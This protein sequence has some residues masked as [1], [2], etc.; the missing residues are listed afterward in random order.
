MALLM[1][2]QVATAWDQAAAECTP[3][4]MQEA[5][6]AYT[7]AKQ[8]ID[9]QQWDMA[10]PRLQSIVE[11]CPEHVVSLRALGLA[12]VHSGQHEM[13]KNVLQRVVEIRADDVEAPDYANLAKAYSK[14]KQYREA[15]AEFMKAQQLAPDDC[16]VL[17]NL[18]V[19]HNAAGVYGQSVDTFEHALEVCPRLKDKILPQL[20]KAC[21]QA[22]KNQR[23]SGNVAEAERYEQLARQYSSSAG[24]STLFAT[25]KTLMTQQK[26]AEAANCFQQVAEGSPTNS[27]AWLNLARCKDQVGQKSASV[28]AFQKY[29]E[30]KP[31]DLRVTADMV[32]VMIEAGQCS[33]A[34]T[35]AASAVAQN[36]GKGRKAVAKVNYAWGKALE[37]TKDYEAAKGKFNE[38]I[39][40]GDTDWIAQARTEVGRMDGFIAREK[41]AKRKAAQG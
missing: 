39:T 33:A 16:G 37:C 19:L 20:T 29:L 3:G 32:M 23:G 7:S 28:V 31:G 36:M 41:A 34:K 5:N 27:A 9:A 40:S 25:G 15:R 4:Q 21:Q 24:G 6:R 26:F 17:F 1:V 8:F 2:F 13:G 14:L 12:Y 38:Y 22:A 11:V 30:L 10:I 35:A 18:G